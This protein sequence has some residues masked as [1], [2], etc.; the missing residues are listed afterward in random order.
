MV[1]QW[2]FK[3]K[4]TNPPICGIHKVLLTRKQLPDELIASGYK[5]FTFL[6]CPVSGQVLND[7]EESK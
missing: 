4:D 2:C 3:Q 7:D 5:A 6:M 1:R